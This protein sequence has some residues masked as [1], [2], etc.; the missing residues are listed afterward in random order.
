MPACQ[1]GCA[2]TSEPSVRIDD[3]PF[4]HRIRV[5]FAE[6]DAMGIV[7]HSRYLPYLEEARV[8]YL[9]AIGHPYTEWRDAGLDSAV[10]EAYVRYRQPLRFDDEVDVHLRL[11]SA[12]RTT[13]QMA[14]LLT[15]GGVAAR[16]PSPSTAWSPPPAAR[17]ACPTGSSSS[18][19][20][21]R[22]PTE[23]SEKRC[24]GSDSM[25]DMEQEDHG[26][27]AG[28]PRRV[29]WRGWKDVL[30]H[31]KAEAKDDRVTLLAAGVA[32]YAL[33]ALVPALVALVSLYGLL[34]DPAEVERQV[35]D[36]LGATPTEVRELVTSQLR[37][38][39]ED[40][41]GALGLAAVLGIV[42][43]LWSASSGVNNLISAINA[44]YDEGETRG[45]VRLRAISLAFTLG[46]IVFLVSSFLLIAV[47]PSVLADTGLGTA[48]RVA[49]SVLRWVL[50]LIGMMVGLGVLYRY[51]PDRNAATWAWISPGAIAA[52]LLWLAGSAAFAVYTANFASYN[53]T[54]GSLA[55][56]VVAMLWLFL[57]ALAII[58]GAELN[59]E[60]ERQ[61]VKDTT[62][63]PPQPMGSR[64]AVAAD[65]LGPTAE[66][67]RQGAHVP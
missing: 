30:V 29:P 57:T 3:Y 61:T 49:A 33:L 32:F 34:A 59:A 26:R 43:A 23:G 21:D 2:S 48:G 58:L 10:L 9:R 54:Y 67:V 35:E 1:L 5:R 56:I 51:G 42:I 50:L 65:T 13:F 31:V 7:H 36:V 28:S 60:L 39:T 37:S 4:T 8:A 64:D 38:I 17:P 12:T 20:G 53:E 46:A 16:R 45:F 22:D 55:G 6:T 47:L 66:E 19:E 41:G 18:P 25:M 63:G 24:L 40:A 44:A 14:Y 52:T 27:Q 15:V 11:A 62:V